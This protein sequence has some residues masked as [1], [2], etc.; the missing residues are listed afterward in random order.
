MQD[1]QLPSSIC[2]VHIAGC[3]QCDKTFDLLSAS[4]CECIVRERSFVCPSCHAC[5]CDASRRQ[6][7]HFVLTSPPALQKRYA[8]EQEK[9]LERLESLRPWSV[10]RPFAI[11]VDDDPIMLSI[12]KRTLG[13]MGYT[14]LA[15]TNPEEAF[16]VTTAIVPDLLLSD[17]LMPRMDGRELC[18]RLKN[19][20]QTKGI[21]IVVMSALYRGAIYRHEAFKQ[22]AVDGYLSKPLTPGVLS[23][24][25]EE[26]LPRAG[27]RAIP[28]AAHTV[29]MSAQQ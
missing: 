16:A 17:A 10:P 5:A 3:F 9:G 29:S 25:I 13:T 1:F 7:D 22:F 4:F 11:V 20:Q 28:T 12:A 27:R 18:R 2:H 15:M 8:R 6:R 19:Q 24:A 21:T 23:S 26:L 14:T